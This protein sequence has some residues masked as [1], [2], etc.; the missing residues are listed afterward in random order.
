MKLLG[1][2]IVRGRLEKRECV[3]MKERE[4]LCLFVLM[5]ICL[6]RFKEQTHYKVQFPMFVGIWQMI[7]FAVFSFFSTFV[8]KYTLIQ[9]TQWF[10]C[11]RLDPGIAWIC[12]SGSHKG[13][14]I[15]L[16]Y[17]SAKQ[18]HPPPPPSCLGEI[19]DLICVGKD[20]VVCLI[21]EQALVLVHSH[22]AKL[23]T[24]G[25]ARELKS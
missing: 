20:A 2:R 7:C 18:N 19:T 9:P 21:S 17:L 14:D 3:F 15:W 24:K 8:F 5:Y 12:A 11:I 23:N 16:L 22:L 6:G 10:F 1:C 13:T 25:E 4:N